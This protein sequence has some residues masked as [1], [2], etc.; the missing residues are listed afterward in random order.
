MTLLITKHRVQLSLT[1]SFTV[2]YT[3]RFH[4]KYENLSK[5]LIILNNQ[6]MFPLIEV[7][8]L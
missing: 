4:L 8:L 2:H 1:H 3:A 6:I 5:Y 7:W